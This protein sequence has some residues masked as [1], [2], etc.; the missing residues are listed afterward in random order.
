MKK[1]FVVLLVPFFLFACATNAS[2]STE[3]TLVYVND[4]S[5]QCEDGGMSGAETAAVLTEANIKVSSTQCGSLSNVAVVAM[6]GG[7]AI[8]IN[9]HEIKTQDLGKAEELGFK[10]VST[11]KQENNKGYEVSDCK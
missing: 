1:L 5:M 8:N 2:K 4:G 6:C 11:L 10:N 3:S 7:P 9:V